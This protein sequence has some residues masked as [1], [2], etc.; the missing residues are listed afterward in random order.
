MKNTF[1]PIVNKLVQLIKKNKWEK[2]FEI[3]IKNA[4]KYKVEQLDDI[5]HLEDYL[6]F[7]NGFL[8]WIPNEPKPIKPSPSHPSPKPRQEEFYILTCT[9]YFI[10]DQDPIKKYQNAI[11]PYDKAPKLTELS[12]W[13]VEYAKE[14]GKFM[15]TDESLK[16][17]DTFYANPAFNMSEYIRP[18]GGWKSYNQF[19]ARN[20]KPGYRPVAAIADSTVIVSPPDSTFDGQWEIR[21]DSQ[22]TVKGLNWKIEELME[23][24]PYK[25]RF[26]NGIFMHAFLSPADYHRQHAPVD[27]VVLEARVISGQC[28][29]QVVVDPPLPTEINGKAKLIPQRAFD[30][31]DDLGYQFAQA[32][33]LIVLDSPIGLVAVLPIG[34]CQVS[35]VIMTAEAGVKLR[36]GEEMSYFQFGGSDVIVL[37]ESASNVSITAQVG[38]HYKMG[39][40]I[41]QAFPVIRKI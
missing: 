36:K 40:R 11:I 23:G 35:S 37:F 19:F 39:T 41:A 1:H 2:D 27:G 31:P 34:M 25:E 6:N 13:I 18:H 7:I 16:H 8:T 17:L 5:H 22:V 30:A 28:Y 29:L 21:A 12:H 4:R 3:A 15:D 38:T 9:F 33:G 14:F 32:R 24:S 26:K 20:F 10:L